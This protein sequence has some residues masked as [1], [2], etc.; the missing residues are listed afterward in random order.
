[1]NDPETVLTAAAVVVAV[2]LMAVFGL[3]IAQP[4]AADVYRALGL[5]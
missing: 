2:A 3:V 1:M 4:V 5:I